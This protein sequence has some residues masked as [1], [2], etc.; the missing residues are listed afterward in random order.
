MG[1]GGGEGAGDGAG[2][3]EGAGAGDGG[4]IAE[5]GGVAERENSRKSNLPHPMRRLAPMPTNIPPYSS[6]R[7]SV[8][9][10]TNSASNEML[11]RASKSEMNGLLRKPRWFD[12]FC[13]EPPVTRTNLS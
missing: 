6:A 1:D 12:S 5:D 7:R 10:S 4:G 11:P 8:S 2:D 3:G 9:G 13:P